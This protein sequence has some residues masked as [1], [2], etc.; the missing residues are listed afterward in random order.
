MVGIL[1][2]QSS[3]LPKG[4]AES[5]WKTHILEQSHFLKQLVRNFKKVHRGRFCSHFSLLST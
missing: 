1:H 5:L 4:K 2:S 3:E